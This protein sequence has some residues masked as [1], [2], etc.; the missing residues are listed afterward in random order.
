MSKLP[1]LQFYT[2][3]WRKDPCVQALDHEHKGVWIDLLCILNETEDR[4]RLVLPSGTPMPDRAIARNLGIDEAK[5]KQI[6]ST[7][8]ALGVAS[9]D[10]DG[11]LYNRRIVRDE[12]V[13]EARRRSGALGGKA[14]GRKR[15]A[16]KDQANKEANPRSSVSSSTS[17]STSVGKRSKKRAHQLPEGWAPNDQHRER[18]ATEGVD[19]DREAEKFRFH[20]EARGSLFVSWDRAFTTWLL[21]ASEFQ[22]NNG[23]RPRPRAAPT[24]SRSELDRFDEAMRGDG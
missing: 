20:H 5:W 8:L 15:T 6:R 3:D 1:A 23:S 21:K 19:C 17:T 7:L 24:M 9:E 4:G 14:S 2:G 13:R 11:V 12:A 18:A 16:S 10:E 22:G